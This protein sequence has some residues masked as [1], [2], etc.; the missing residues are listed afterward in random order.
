RRVALRRSAEGDRRFGRAVP[1]AGTLVT[2]EGQEKNEPDLAPGSYSYERR[3]DKAKRS[4]S[5]RSR[6]LRPRRRRRQ[7]H[8]PLR[9]LLDGLPGRIVLRALG[10]HDGPSPVTALP[11]RDR[12]R[13]LRQQLRAQLVGQLLAAALAENGRWLAAA[14]ADER[15]HVLDDAQNALVG[16]FRHMRGPAGYARCDPL[17][18]G[19]DEH[20]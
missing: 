18:R 14:R 9:Q 6:A 4:C 17:R 1:R 16:L 10:E 8:G 5:R 12:K 20:V 7:L 15:R 3:V 13:N 19:D 11:Q 2:G